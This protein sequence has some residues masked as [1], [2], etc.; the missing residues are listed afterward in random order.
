MSSAYP[1]HFSGHLSFLFFFFQFKDWIPMKLRSCII[2][3][4]QCQCCDTLY[5]GKT[6]HQLHVRISD[7]MAISAHTGNKISQTSISSVLTHSKHTGHPISYDDFSV[8]ASGTLQFDVLICESWLIS[9]LKPSLNTLSLT[10]YLPPLSTPF[11]F[12]NR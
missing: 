12:C 10:N 9:R 8:L 5:L 7:H 3:K 1:H 6:C 2:Y 11:Y 4:F